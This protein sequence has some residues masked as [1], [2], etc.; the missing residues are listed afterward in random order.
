MHACL[1]DK[2]AAVEFIQTFY[3]LY[4]WYINQIGII[5]SFPH[6]HIMQSDTINNKFMK[7][8]SS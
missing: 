1:Y 5:F 8:I 3:T 2:I 7:H 6:T 4:F